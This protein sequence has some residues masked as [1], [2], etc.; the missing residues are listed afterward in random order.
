MSV[1]I[2]RPMSLMNLFL[3]G[4]QCSACVVYLTLMVLEIG[5]KWLYCCCLEGCYF[6]DLSNIACNI[7]MQ[8][9]SSFFLYAF[10]QCLCDASIE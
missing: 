2:Y 4:Q 9:P 7:L 5:G 6:K 8:F 3:L 1:G 10:C